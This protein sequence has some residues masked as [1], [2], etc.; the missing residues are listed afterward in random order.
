MNKPKIAF[1]ITCK[2][3]VQHLEKTLPKNLKDNVY[4]NLVFIVLDYNSQDHLIEYL[5]TYQSEINSGRLVV[6][7]LKD[8]GPFHMT[9]AKNLAHRCGILEGAD[10]LV[11]LDADNYTG[12]GFAEW[13]ANNFKNDSFFW[14]GVVQGLGKK[15]RGTSGRIV[16]SKHAF[17][18]AGGYDE[19]YETW[20]PD[21]KD[22]NA[23]LCRL[24]YRPVEMERRFLEAIPHK[25]GLRF[26]E[27]PHIQGNLEDENAVIISET[28]VVNFG[29]FGE[30][31]VY[32]NFSEIPTVL[33]PVPTRL[34]G[35]G[36][37]KTATT[38]L[39]AAFDILGFDH[40]HWGSGGQARKI[41][42]E[43]KSG[44]SLTLEKHYAIS[45]LPIPL[46][47]KELD[48]AYPGSKFIL[49][50]RDEKKWLRSVMHHWSYEFNPY[51]WEWDKYPF[52]NRIH[53]AIYGQVTFDPDVFINRYRKHNREVKEYFK[54]RKDLLVMDMETA[55]WSE[56][57][58][59]LDRPIPNVSY[60]RKLVTK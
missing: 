38:S 40:S 5:K 15:F 56:L 2:G 34:F 31:T 51:R 30:G 60:P 26:K 9:H 13:V 45:D 17:L 54:D 52:S 24:G 25:D 21:D 14:S 58:P 8:S 23:R 39:D 33:G 32:K 6:Y 36:L 12:E 44:R 55:G 27:Y 3:R 59:F 43:I 16:V 41:Y 46:I 11:N 29:H 10:I 50:E 20:A 22:F 4:E 19:K 42:E 37:H 48:I 35:I 18:N 49:T 28:T 7:S 57:C 1:C 47:Y 53:K